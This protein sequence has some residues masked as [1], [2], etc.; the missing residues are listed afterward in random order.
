MTD[1]RPGVEGPRGRRV[2]GFSPWEDEFGYSRAVVAGPF[3]LVSGCTAWDD[4]RVQHEGDPY[5][6][7]RSAFGVAFQ[8]LAKLG[9]EPRHV[10]RTRM[11]ITH[12]RDA[13]DVGRA[14]KELF[15][16]V[17]PAATMVVVNGLID[18]R[19]VVEVEV[20]AYHPGLTPGQ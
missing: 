6:Q 4:G 7:T 20:D 11:F 14:H 13:D 19:M 8:A 9:L 16:G 18:S 5:E 15:D 12:A 2:A 17:R 10:V 3:A 1:A